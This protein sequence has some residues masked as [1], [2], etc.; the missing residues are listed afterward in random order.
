[1]LK[2][3]REWYCGLWFVCVLICCFLLEK[4]LIALKSYPFLIA[5]LFVV[6]FVS[7]TKDTED[8]QL[9]ESTGANAMRNPAQGLQF[10]YDQMLASSL[11]A[12]YETSLSIFVTKMG[13]DAEEE[14]FDNET[15]MLDWIDDNLSKT[16]FATYNDAVIAWEAVK[17]EF[18][19]V[20]ADNKDLFDTEW[21][22][23][24]WDELII[25]I[26]EFV[27]SSN[28]CIFD[29]RDESNEGFMQAAQAYRAALRQA[30]ALAAANPVAGAS[31]TAVA[32]LQFILD[33]QWV[34]R[35]FGWCLCLCDPELCPGS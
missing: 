19:L 20:V 14:S 1:M 4:G 13:E 7:C 34:N 2:K 10:Y 21:D 3:Q 30:N 33:K 35:R 27:A 24:E 12:D 17:D 31:A 26:P 28:E 5:A 22:K 11:Y 25:P 18:E 29:C 8:L 32:N 15:E 23:D 6:G 16:D 9:Q